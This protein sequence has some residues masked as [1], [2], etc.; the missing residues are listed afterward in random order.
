MSSARRLTV[1]S[2]SQLV[3]LAITLVVAACAHTT[4]HAAA[5]PTTAYA[6]LTE[7]Q[8]AG[9]P[10]GTAYQL[11][12]RLRPRFL[13][14][15]GGL[16]NYQPAVYVDGVR[17]GGGIAELERIDARSVREIRYLTAVEATTL[18]GVGRF[19]GAVLVSTRTRP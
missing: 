4:S 14:S 18:Y 3:L 15:S 1:S 10:A 17:L 12:T 13:K 9:A 8:I 2:A 16:G 5:V 6:P 7:A 11:V 19:S